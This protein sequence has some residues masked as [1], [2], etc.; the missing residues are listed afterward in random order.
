MEQKFIVP[1]FKDNQAMLIS[2]DILSRYI[3]TQ[4]FA[5]A[6]PTMAPKIAPPTV[7]LGSP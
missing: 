5:I 2:P 1:Y 6:F 7:A 3:M 4:W